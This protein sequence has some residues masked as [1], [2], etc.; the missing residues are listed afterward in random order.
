MKFIVNVDKKYTVWENL[1]IEIDAKDSTEA[2]Q[3]V[4]MHDGCPPNCD[5][6]SSEVI[7][8]TEE[9]MTKDDNGGNPVFEIKEIVSK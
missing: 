1:T 2:K 5:F 7:I 9:A 8:D 6:L 3:M 4:E